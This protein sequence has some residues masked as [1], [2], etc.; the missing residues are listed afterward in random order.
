MPVNKDRSRFIFAVDVQIERE[1]ADQYECLRE[2]P[3]Y[4]NFYITWVCMNLPGIFWACIISSTVVLFNIK[5][6]FMDSLPC[7]I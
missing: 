7:A 1:Q 6:P 3:Y 2:S 5:D 4:V